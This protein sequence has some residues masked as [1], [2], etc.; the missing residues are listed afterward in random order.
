MQETISVNL[1][2]DIRSALERALRE[3]GISPEDL[4]G[5]AVD[6]YLFFRRLRLLRER[7]TAKARAQGIRSEQDVFDRVS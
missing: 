5:K 3:E 2:E 1:P 7:M 4:I 6:E